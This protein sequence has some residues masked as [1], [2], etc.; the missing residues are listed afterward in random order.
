MLVSNF[1]VHYGL[2]KIKLASDAQSKIVILSLLTYLVGLALVSMTTGLG[3]VNGWTVD[4]VEHDLRTASVTKFGKN[5]WKRGMA[6]SDIA[7]DNEQ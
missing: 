1:M 7:E 6:L 5:I 4:C 3:I 2:N